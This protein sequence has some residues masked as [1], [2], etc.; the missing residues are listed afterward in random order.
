M[1]TGKT[2][3]IATICVAI[4][5]AMTEA[6]TINFTGSSSLDLADAGATSADYVN[7]KESAQYGIVTNAAPIS[8]AGLNLYPKSIY[9]LCDGCSLML[10]YGLLLHGSSPM[11]PAIFKQSGGTFTNKYPVFVAATS[12]NGQQGSESGYA[13]YLF[14][15]GSATM[16]ALY[17]S[18]GISANTGKYPSSGVFTQTGGDFTAPKLGFGSKTQWNAEGNCQTNA[19]AFVRLE[20]GVFNLGADRISS[21]RWNE[22]E[23]GED[24]GNSTYKI[25]LAG[26]TLTDGAGTKADWTNTYQLEVSDEGSSTIDWGSKRFVQAA[27]LW[28]AG[29]LVKSGS[30]EMILTDAT[31]FTGTL[32]VEA[33]SVRVV[34]VLADNY[35][36]DCIIFIGDKASTGLSDGAPISSWTDE[37]G[38]LTAQMP[39]AVGLITASAWTNVVLN[40][41]VSAASFNGHAGIKFTRSGTDVTGLVI[42]ADS[43]PLR[44]A[45]NFT[46][47]V[48]FRKSTI[49]SGSTTSDYQYNYNEGILGSGISYGSN[50]FGLSVNN[51]C[52]PVA[53]RVY[54]NGNASDGTDLFCAVVGGSGVCD[55]NVHVMAYS[56]DGANTVMSIDGVTV[57]KTA[58]GLKDGGFPL[59][60][61]PFSIG[62][63]TALVW[64]NWNAASPKL[65]F[66]GEIAEIRLYRNRA[67]GVSELNAVCAVLAEKYAGADAAHLAVDRTEVVAAQFSSADA[68]ELPS[69][70]IEFD[71]DS[72]SAEDGDEV[73]SWTDVGNS[74]TATVEAGL[75]SAGP[76]LVH[77]AFGNAALRFDGAA[78][79]ALG[80]AA[81]D[82]P[83]TGLND[84]TVAVVFR[85]VADGNA[86][87]SDQSANNFVEGKGIVSTLADGVWKESFDTVIGFHKDGVVGTGS[88][89]IGKDDYLM[90][91]KPMRMNDGAAHIVV[92]AIDGTNAKI[93]RLVDGHFREGTVSSNGARVSENL[94]IGSLRSNLDGGYFTGDIAAVVLWTKALES[95]EMREVQEHYAK[96][97]GVRTLA[98]KA[99]VLDDVS[100]RGIGATN[101]H[102]AA[103]ATFSAPTTV[104]HPFTLSSMQTLTG[105][106]EFKGAYRFVGGVV[107]DLGAVIAA[108]IE[109]VQIADGAVLKVPLSALSAP[110]SMSTVSSVSGSVVLDMSA[111]K[112]AKMPHRLPV[113]RFG[114]GAVKD[115]ARFAVTGLKG[116]H[117]TKVEG[118]VLFVESKVGFML[119]LR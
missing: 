65:A 59:A 25:Q 50:G 56:V 112:G 2:R 91:T 49:G 19:H 16:S 11:H 108:N 24:F 96:K 41:T 58:E 72:I 29:T 18:S 106:G 81:D 26:G 70:A 20:G 105:L 75:G 63:H 32:D 64:N 84:V 8:L 4:A 40:P 102:V 113:L 90:M 79:T 48:V 78:K 92:F 110:V 7:I 69:G 97:F 80:I 31:R 114:F 35:T 68:P 85:T 3:T 95:D 94:K 89:R 34:G 109:D 12:G 66:E 100:D 93:R 62:L 99:F 101:I 43:N 88:S 71:A 86:Y 53:G 17:V 107:M 76:T 36:D 5:S 30:G 55:G 21:Y 37:S 60:K 67:M 111:F 117:A 14:A 33:G 52:W 61:N 15:G 10:E 23:A 74:V 87:V 77:D 82:S 27:P 45:T 116:E 104:A 46:A 57:A 119:I 22:N 51:S 47:V 44:D 42:P 28:G 115:S 13:E 38:A 1:T 98:R 39:S 73:T 9:G 6:V 83:I 118:G 103:G 54:D